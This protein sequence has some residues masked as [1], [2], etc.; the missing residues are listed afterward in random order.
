MLEK[1][2]IFADDLK[3]ANM[4]I[5]K[6]LNKFIKDY[7]HFDVEAFIDVDAEDVS[8][9]YL[10]K[11]EEEN[12]EEHEKDN[13]QEE[14]AEDSQ[15]VESEEEE[16]IET[17]S[18]VLDRERHLV[19]LGNPG[20]GK[21]TILVHEALKMAKAYLQG[22]SDNVPIFVSLKHLMSIAE[23][24][25]Y[26]QIAK[27]IFTN[28][29]AQ[30]LDTPILF[31]DGLNELNHQI[32]QQAI[33]SLKQFI[34]DWPLV[35]VVITSRKYGY[36]NQ[37]GIP[38]YEIQVFDE[39]DIALYIKKRIGNIQMLI[40]LRKNETLFSLCSTPLILKM[41]V[42][43]WLTTGHLPIKLSSLYQEFVENQLSKNL[44]ASRQEK[45]TLLYVMSILAFEL[46]NTGFIS[47]SAEQVKH[48][49]EYYIDEANIKECDTKRIC[50]MLMRSGLVVIYDRGN[51]FEYVSFLHE[52]FQEF[53]CSLYI[54]DYYKKCNSFPVDIT[55]KE[56]AE[57]VRLALEL[58]VPR[59]S[60]HELVDLLKFIQK[61]F[62][63]TNRDVIDLNLPRYI[64]LL[65]S[66]IIQ[67]PIIYKWLEQ[68]ILFNMNNYMALPPKS[69]TPFRFSIII[70]SIMGLASNKLYTLLFF[71][72]NGWM[73][74]W[75]YT[76]QELFEY[77]SNT[78]NTQK[79]LVDAKARIA[80]HAAKRAKDKALLYKFI[81][82]AEKEHALFSTAVLRLE[83]L[84]SKLTESIYSI[85]AK[86]I[87]AQNQSL[88]FL[89]LTKDQEMIDKEVAKNGY[90]FEELSALNRQTILEKYSETK[91]VNL[92]GYYYCEIFPK[93]QNFGL[94]DK[95][96]LISNIRSCP[97][98]ID[99]LIDSPFWSRH[100]E[101]L[102]QTMY[103]LPEKYWSNRYLTAIDKLLNQ[104]LLEYEEEQEEEELKNEQK[105]TKEIEDEQKVKN[106]NRKSVTHKL[107]NLGMI[108]EEYTYEF[109]E[110]TSR[111]KLRKWFDGINL[112]LLSKDFTPMVMQKVKLS[113]LGPQENVGAIVPISQQGDWEEFL[114]T[115][116]LI[117]YQKNE[118][119]ETYYFLVENLRDTVSVLKYQ[120][121]DGIYYKRV[122]NA[123]K[124]YILSK[125]LVE[126]INIPV[127]L[128][129]SPKNYAVLKNNY[130]LIASRWYYL[131]PK[132][133]LVP[134]IRNNAVNMG[135]EKLIERGWI[136]LI[137]EA[138]KQKVTTSYKF[139]L[140]IRMEG[141][142]IYAVNKYGQNPKKVQLK[143]YDL[144]E[145]GD[146]LVEYKDLFYKM[147][148]STIAKQ[149]DF[150]G[151][152]AGTITRIVDKWAWIYDCNSQKEYISQVAKNM[153]V[154]QNIKFW[155]TN[156]ISN[157]D[158]S[159]LEAFTSQH[160]Q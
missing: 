124:G 135:M 77:L 14:D 146:I 98:L 117:D 72:L 99:T 144:C 145:V 158:H 4:N 109:E 71:D 13:Q 42:D 74:E 43:T 25:E 36:K 20:T 34:M 31:L 113:Y 73:K 68:Y 16:N 11:I 35:K 86:R 40:E 5:S 32:H 97:A 58:I 130:S 138:F 44:Q 41:L 110:K 53:L 84:E 147:E 125:K 128:C 56:W 116:T 21:S 85:E 6:Y 65:D 28:Y 79:K 80:R 91:N 148:P 57:T 54:S 83:K 17:I 19:I 120:L 69:R 55:N 108:G 24:E 114:H 118:S 50:D 1:K 152:K 137:P 7:Q 26:L 132:S 122:S 107:R 63:A 93:Y 104:K 66:N 51:G 81:K 134:K 59:L 30:T 67:Y 102:A 150:Y 149:S 94:L 139:Y 115:H 160:L 100:F 9:F 121:K 76:D 153:K 70:E 46:R 156:I 39:N 64:E 103:G 27:D 82:K 151:F 129:S 141:K 88:Y 105:A 96:I 52:T 95:Q 33:T 29:S 78:S 37:L 127:G 101:E 155:P 126:E 112:S 123:Y 61:S 48:I 45:Q 157:A 133:V 47:D 154:D 49:I 87:Y 8:S 15:Q 18:S 140:I 60:E 12:E 92:L 62:V 136:G 2:C 90:N 143:D 106:S 119:K 38:Q 75:L 22:A 159:S 10:A 111:K 3:Q 89:L 131:M 142:K 23:L